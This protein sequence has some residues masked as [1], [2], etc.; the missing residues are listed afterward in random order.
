MCI[1]DRLWEG[2]VSSVNACQ[3]EIES[4]KMMLEK[5]MREEYCDEIEGTTFKRNCCLI[6]LKKLDE[7][8]KCLKKEIE[9]LQTVRWDQG[10]IV[11]EIEIKK[12]NLIKLETIT[13]NIE[14]LIEYLVKKF[15]VDSSQIRKEFNIPDEFKEFMNIN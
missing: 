15:N 8:C 14:L 9:K 11:E 4:K 3:K 7:E 10:K 5:A 1:R 13:D 12:E 2:L 6:E